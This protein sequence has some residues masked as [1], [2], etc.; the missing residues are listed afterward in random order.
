M[1]ESLKGYHETVNFKERP[2]FRLYHNDEAEDYPPHWHSNPE[3]IMPLKSGY[4]VILGET[5]YSLGEDDI[6]FISSSTIHNLIAPPKGERLIFQPDFS[7]ITT[8]PELSSAV[9]MLSPAIVIWKDKD[10]DIAPRLKE[11]LLNIEKEYYSKTPLAGANIYSMLI[12]ML[13]TIGRKYSTSTAGFDVSRDKQQEYAEKFMEVCE[14]INAHFSEDLKLEDVA[15]MAGFSKFHFT[16][17]FKQF[18]GKTF[19]RYVNLKRI[20]HAEMLLTE[21]SASVTE[22]AIHSGFSSLPAF[23]RMF[24]LIKGCTPTEFRRMHD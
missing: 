13:V 21:P 16:R 24:K 18:T 12:E 4:D 5:K 15:E 3:I 22:I 6:I 9:T 2:M 8:L 20:E 1:I 7:L 19:Y 10:T 11:L 14:Y 23:V 17:L